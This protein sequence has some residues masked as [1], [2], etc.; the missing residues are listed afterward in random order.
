MFML[1]G[2]LEESDWKWFFCCADVGVLI[3][4]S[5]RMLHIWILECD[6]EKNQHSQL[7]TKII[8]K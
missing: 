3:G 6:V 1:T 4:Q 7:M 2:S 5:G 8:P